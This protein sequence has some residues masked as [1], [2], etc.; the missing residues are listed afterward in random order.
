MIGKPLRKREVQGY[1]QRQ[2]VAPMLQ[3]DEKERDKL[4]DG[5]LLTTAISMYNI[6][7]SELAP[8]EQEEF[9]EEESNIDD[10]IAATLEEEDDYG[11]EDYEGANEEIEEDNT[12]IVF[13]KPSDRV[14]AANAFVKIVGVFENRKRK[15]DNSRDRSQVIIP[16]DLT[17]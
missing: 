3:L 1:V 5:M 13:Y 4:F 10:I 16:K 15:I 6:A 7:N 8:P 9:I 17:L 2:L 12:G 14:N 11:E